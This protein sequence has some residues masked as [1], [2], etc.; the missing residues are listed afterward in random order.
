MLVRRLAHNTY[1]VHLKG[2]GTIIMG[3]HSNKCM[4]AQII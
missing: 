4:G 2:Q 1:N 3:R